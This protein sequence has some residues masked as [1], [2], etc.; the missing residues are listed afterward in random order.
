VD[1][2]YNKRNPP[3]DYTGTMKNKR[4]EISN[5]SYNESK[6]YDWQPI[7]KMNRNGNISW[8]QKYKCRKTGLLGIRRGTFGLI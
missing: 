3:I 4:I 2:Q 6:K 5:L 8:S 1:R 7:E